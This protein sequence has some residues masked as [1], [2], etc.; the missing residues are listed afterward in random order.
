M[1]LVT[2][3]LMFRNMRGWGGGLLAFQ[4]ALILI[5]LIDRHHAIEIVRYRT[6]SV[7][8]S[9]MVLVLEIDVLSDL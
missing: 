8:E 7:W 4:Y 2:D 9:G 3:F 1:A 6:P 5:C